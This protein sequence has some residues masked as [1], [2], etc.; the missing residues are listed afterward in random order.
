MDRYGKVAVQEIGAKP[1]EKRHEVL[2]S[3]H[4]AETSYCYDDTY[5]V[6]LPTKISR[7]LHQQYKDLKKIPFAKFASN[8]TMMDKASLAALLSTGKFI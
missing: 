6:I 7:L 2:I 3:E 4:E 5:Y 1:G 8:T